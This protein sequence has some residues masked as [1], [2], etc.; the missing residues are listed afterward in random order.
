MTDLTIPPRG[1]ISRLPL[2][3]KNLAAPVILIALALAF[4]KLSSSVIKGES[5]VFDRVLI[6]ALRNPDDPS[7]P[8][9]PDWL[10]LFMVDIT[11]FGGITGLCLIVA[12]ATAYL[13]V[14]RNWSTALFLAGT[15]AG[16]WIV[17]DLLKSFFNRQRPDLVGHLVEV[18]S[19]SFPS[20][21]AM[22]SAVVFLTL[23]AL[24]A[25]NH[26]G[27]G[28]RIYI[29]SIA[30]LLTVTIGFSRVY[31]GV[32]WPSDVMAGWIAGGS[33][34]ALCWY[35]GRPLRRRHQLEPTA[36]SS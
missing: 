3:A 6:S 35:M 4:F 5:L 34:A 25:G 29:L 13:L 23:G 17:N 8:I 32:H 24:I 1:L 14:Q 27:R 30:I 31:L 20:S 11:A 21:H 28:A 22:N 7:L 15:T 36:A 33:W 18:H 2:K 9:G 10:R 12:V 26:T 16:G 19:L